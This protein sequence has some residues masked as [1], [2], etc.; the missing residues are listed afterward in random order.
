MLEQEPPLGILTGRPKLLPSALVSFSNR[1]FRWFYVAMLGQMASLNMQLVVPGLLVFELTGSF[2]ALGLMGLFSAMPL[3]LLSMFGGVLA[4]RMPK[5]T[6]LVAGQLVS[7]FNA[8][9]M[10]ALVFT[11]LM[12]MEWLYLSAL[13]QGTIWAL[14]LPASQAIIPDIV[15]MDR[16]MNAVSLN[17]AGLNSKQL[18]APAGAGFIISFAGFE[19]AFLAMASLYGVALA[20]LARL[21]WQPATVASE[22]G[23]SLRQMAVKGF[24][25]IGQG[26]SYIRGRRLMFL[27]LSITF[28]SSMFA[29]SHLLLLPGYVADVLDGGGSK[30][31]L[32]FSVSACG[33]LVAMLGLAAAP[34]RRRGML[35]LASMM[36]LGAGLLA[37]AQTS[38]YWLAAAIMLS[39]G[40]GTALRQ[41]LI[42]GL[43]QE[44]TDPG[45]QGRV[46]ALFMQ[47]WSILTFGTFIVGI[48]AEI[49]GV[50]TAFMALGI[51][52]MLVT[53]AVYAFI[54]SIRN[55][56]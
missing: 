11:D 1:D 42:Q 52:L 44:Y 39:I 19:W 22:P 24:E 13:V 33:S 10:S 37:F 50:Q 28:V 3:L 5:R 34:H 31:G 27:L 7:L 30:V 29:M 14:M 17:F 16:L 43:L 15:G 53:L 55:L 20:G 4:D 23:M 40:V 8:A 47:Q 12:S 26:L 32:M 35:L 18:L 45:Y 36:V 51:G 48:A 9:V 38:D 41:A 56:T 25:D 54:P 49:V 6:I 2:A 46:M 21:T